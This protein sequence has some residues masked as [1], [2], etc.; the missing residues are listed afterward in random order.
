MFGTRSSL[1]GGLA[2]TLTILF[3]PA[4]LWAQWSPSNKHALY[5]YGYNPGYYA[6]PTL[7]IPPAA[8]GYQA[9]MMVERHYRNTERAAMAAAAAPARSS[10]PEPEPPPSSLAVGINPPAQ[11]TSVSIRGPDGKVRTFPLASPD[12]IRPRTIIVRSGERL[13]ITLN[14]TVSVR[15]QRK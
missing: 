2:L 5:R 12:A 13:S 14:G 4:P 6:G 1:F 15:I 11:P 8:K 3:L 10:T 9:T 7:G